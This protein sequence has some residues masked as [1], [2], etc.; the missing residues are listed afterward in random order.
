MSLLYKAFSVECQYS[1]LHM[2]HNQ[3]THRSTHVER[4]R[5]EHMMSR[6]QAH[7]QPHEERVGALPQSHTELCGTPVGSRQGHPRYTGA[8]TEKAVGGP[9][10]PPRRRPTTNDH[11]TQTS[12]QDK[13]VFR[14]QVL[15]DTWKVTW[16]VLH[17]GGPL[18]SNT[19]SLVRWVV[20]A[21]E[22]EAMRE[23]G[24]LAMRVGS[25]ICLRHHLTA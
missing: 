20:A 18:P 5:K 19:E 1:Q 2:S 23:W 4:E 14:K 11:K 17:A 8:Q 15:T 7:Q 22:C 3:L 10:Q 25:F 13:R 16:S 6:L 21:R 9:Q 12:V 24:F